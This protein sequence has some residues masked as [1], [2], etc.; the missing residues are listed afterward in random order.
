MN[1]TRLCSA[2]VISALFALAV[3]AAPVAAAGAS[4]SQLNSFSRLNGF[5][6]GTG[7]VPVIPAPLGVPDDILPADP[8]SAR[9]FSPTTHSLGPF[10][11][12][13]YVPNQTAAEFSHR[14]QS[15]GYSW[16][17]LFGPRHC[18]YCGC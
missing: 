6:S 1:T 8:V 5:S 16:N 3:F 9:I 4:F 15:Y 2:L 14:S 11:I 17:D 18:G 12:Q 13:P 7:A 10:T